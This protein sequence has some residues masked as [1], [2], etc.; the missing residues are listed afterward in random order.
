[1]SAP[2]AG[3]GDPDTTAMVVPVG[4]SALLAEVSGTTRVRALYSTLLGR[5]RPAGVL[6]VVPA[7][8]T[9]LVTFDS[10]A[11]STAVR[12]WLLDAAAQPAR[13]LD[14]SPARQVE[15]E[16]RYDGADLAEVATLCSMRPEEL[17]RRHT[18]ITWTAIFCGFAPG[19]TYL[20]ETPMDGEPPALQEIPRRPS[21]R[22]SVPAGSVALAGCYCG[23]YPRPSPG[24]WQLIGRT[25]APLWSLERDP[26]ALIEPGTQVRFVAAR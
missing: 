14:R 24:G 2:A 6:D 1:M 17:V 10:P 15:I 3:S 11:R 25:D 13:S 19:F 8:T 9:V 12:T 22:T 4:E 18:S 7:E 26:P 5:E 20:V 23:V 21:P 16:T